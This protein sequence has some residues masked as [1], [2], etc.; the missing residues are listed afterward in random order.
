V[1]NALLID[2][3][4]AIDAEWFAR[5]EVTAKYTPEIYAWLGRPSSEQAAAYAEF[6]ASGF[7][8]SPNLRPNTSMQVAIE[9]EK[10]QLSALQA[11]VTAKESS[12]LVRTAYQQKLQELGNCASLYGAALAGDAAEFAR[13]NEALYGRPDT[14]VF[15]AVC[16]WYRAW[17]TGL[18]AAPTPLVQ[19]V[20]EKLPNLHEPHG[21]HGQVAKLR[22]SDAV[23]ADQ[24]HKH[25]SQT[26][27]QGFY[28]QLF[29]G[30]PLPT[31]T[32]TPVTG[33]RLIK[34]LLANVQAYDYQIA[35]SP[36]PFWGLRYSTTSVVR[37][38]TY[39]LDAQQFLGVVGHEIGSHLLERLNGRR[40]PLRLLG[41]G[42]QG[43]EQGNEG[44]ALLR[45]QVVYPS[46]DEFA[47][48]ERWHHILRRH[49]A[50]SLAVGLDGVPRAFAEV[51][52]IINAI[53]TLWAAQQNPHH[54]TDSH[55][56]QERANGSTW[57][58]LYRVLAGTD[59][60]D[61]SAYYKDIVY[62]EGNINCWRMAA[63]QPE[64]IQMGDLGKIDI[65]NPAHME[66]LT[67][68]M[69]RF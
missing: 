41:F 3:R 34:Q 47:K 39:A 46:W 60:T 65:A 68:C 27:P 12:D 62:L 30:L 69:E 42:L 56:L 25:M 11:E 36:N 26:S 31:G 2:E 53:D 10:Q 43:Y 58:L 51:F 19:A 23:F 66:M 67:S 14:A 48:Q 18:S 4:P 64:S 59:N 17:A 24:R 37:P 7:T 8:T 13:L 44:R 57:E 35:D 28:P 61:G 33:D 1:T 32:V 55:Q 21:S 54:S 29:Q 38:K 50:I 5:L 40:Q 63:L 20:L 15:V 45:E 9:A 16:A 52:A 6:A 49:L 22:P